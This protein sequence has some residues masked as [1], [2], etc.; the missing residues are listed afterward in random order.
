MSGMISVIIPARDAE[1]TLEGCLRAVLAQE[2]LDQPYEVIVVDDGSTDSTA[3][4]AGR[5]AVHLVS[6]PGEGPAAARNKGAETSDGEIIAF[7]DADCEPARDW[8]VNLVEPFAD[9]TIVGVRGAYKTRRKSSVARFVQLEYEFKYKRMTKLETIDFVDTYSAA[10]R[11]RV[12]MHNK[13]FETAFPQ[14]SVEDQEL[15]FRLAS[16]GYR[17][18][19]NPQAIVYHPHDQSIREYARRKFG[20]GYWKAFLL[21]WLPEKALSDSHT[22]KTQRLQIALLAVIGISS[23]LWII[24]PTAVWAF[25]SA[26]LLFFLSSIPILLHV[27]KEEPKLFLLAPLLLVVRAGSLGS[28]LLAGILVPASKIRVR[29]SGFTLPIW[30]F[31]RSIDVLGSMIGLLLSA[32]LIALSAI[33]IRLDSKGPVFFIQDR[34]GENG[35]TFRMVKLRT[36]VVGAESQVAQVLATNPLHGPVFKI[37]NDPRITRVGRYLRRLSLDELPQL[38]NVLK[39]EMSLVGP[40]PEEGWIVEQYDDRQRVRLAVKPGLTG[41][42]QVAGRGD[43]DMGERLELELAYIREFTILKDVEILLRSIPAVILGRGAY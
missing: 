37:P 39:G 31:K 16:K 7:T 26:L 4:I 5:F 10:Y 27:F 11:R 12:F 23:I 29:G 1:E 30:L 21:K 3:E 32:P 28:G 41:P 36:M 40:R 19:F 8:L 20:I 22:P 2:G 13:G 25:V 14:A 15:S 42:A 18:V 34:V 17:M 35:R 38:W 43:L 24:W 9:P 33:A 6:T